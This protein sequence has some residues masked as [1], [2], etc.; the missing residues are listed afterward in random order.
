M[1]ALYLGLGSNLGDRTAHLEW[2]LERIADLPQ[3]KLLQVSTIRETE[4]VGGPSQGNYLNAVAEVETSA[5]AEQWLQWALALEKERGRVRTEIHGPR[6]LDID[7]LW[8]TDTVCN[9][10]DLQLPHPRLR[11]RAFVLEPL[12]ELAPHLIIENRTVQEWLNR[13]LEVSSI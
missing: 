7:L 4:P 1:S 9:T 3:S 6:V 2:A 13:L 12:A 11:H 5:S 8:M 10:S